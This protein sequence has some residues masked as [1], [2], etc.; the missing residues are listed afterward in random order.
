MPTTGCVRKRPR[1][2]RARH[3]RAHRLCCQ[4]RNR[5]RRVTTNKPAPGAH[6]RLRDALRERVR[7]D[8][9][10]RERVRDR[11]RLRDRLAVA[12]ADCGAA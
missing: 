7:E 6:L 1:H 9:R 5:A 3:K 4:R 12:L 10:E 8:V 2:T 11:D